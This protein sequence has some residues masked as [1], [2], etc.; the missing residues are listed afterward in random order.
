MYKSIAILI[1]IDI[2][3]M[4][5]CVY[6]YIY[7]HNYIAQNN[8]LYFIG[9]K[10]GKTKNKNERNSVGPKINHDQRIKRF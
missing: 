10:I 7:M 8:L 5:V 3:C 2:D 1:T 6:I 9:L 4:I